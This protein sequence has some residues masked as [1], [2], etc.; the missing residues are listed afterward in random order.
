MA[1]MELLK[2]EVTPLWNGQGPKRLAE[3]LFG[4]LVT[5]GRI[6]DEFVD[7][8]IMAATGWT[9]ATLMETPA[10]VVEKMALYLAVRQARDLGG[11]LDFPEAQQY[12]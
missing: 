5:G 8:H 6:P 7:A 10:D 12:G 11:T 2:A 9:W 3:A 1:A 4:S